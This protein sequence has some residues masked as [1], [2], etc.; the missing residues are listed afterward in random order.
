MKSS[1]LVNSLNAGEFSPFMGGRSDFAKYA[2][3]SK[4]LQNFI[5]LVQG[6][7]TRRGGTYHA[8]AKKT[9][10]SRG[11][12]VRFEFSAT[13][14]W[15][16]E[17]GD[18]Y[19]R[20][21][22]NHG[23]VVVSGVTAWS[24]VTAYV[25]GDLVVSG[26]INYYCIL[27]H[28]NQIPPN[29]TYWYALTG[30][31]YEI[32]SPYALADLTNA[33]GT[34]ALKF[35]Q[36]GDVIYIANQKRTYAPRKLTRYGSTNWQFSTYAPSTGPFLEQNITATTLYAS[37]NTGSVTLQ[38][39]A[40]IFA[41]S[42][43][44]RL[45]R[46]EVQDQD[47]APWETAKVYALNDLSRFDGK[48]YKVTDA[49][50]SGTSPPI[51]EH[52]KAYDGT[53]T[54][55]AVQWSYQESGYAI[56]RI[57]AFTDANTVTA[58]VIADEANG[59]NLV[60]AALVGAGT[61]SK[62]WSLGAWSATTEYPS[63][64]TFWRDRLCWAG[65]QRYWISVPNDFENM[66]GDFFNEVRADNAIWRQLQAE[67]VN[68]IVWLSGADELVIGTP[69]GEFVVTEITNSQ[70]LGPANIKHKR[71]S[72][73]RCR[74]VQPVSIGTKLVYA[75]RAGRKLLSFGYDFNTDKFRSQDLAVLADRMTRAGIVDMA[76]Q[77]EPFPVMWCVLSN[78]G[79]IGFTYD[80][81]NEV[82]GWHRHPLGGKEVVVESVEV[83]PAPNGLH[84]EVWLMV[85]RTINAATAR[86]I[87]YM[88]R[89]WEGVD[90]DGQGG[91]D[92]QDAFYVDAGLT[93]EGAPDTV[94][95]DDI[96]ITQ[97][98]PHATPI[99]SIGT[100][101]EHFLLV[102]QSIVVT[103]IVATGSYVLNG[104]LTVKTVIS[105]TRFTIQFAG[106]GA[107][108][109][110][111][112]SGGQFPSLAALA[113]TITG[114]DHLEGETV[115]ILTDGAVHPDRTVVSGDI[116]LTAPA[117]VAHIG[118]A[119]PARIVTSDLEAGGQAGTSMG[120]AA[121][122]YWAAVRFVDT[123]GGMI[124]RPAEDLSEPST[125]DEIEY[126][127]PDNAMDSPP[128]TLSGIVDVP[129]PGEWEREKSVEIL[130]YQPLP[131]TVANIMPRLH[132]NDD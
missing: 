55:A 32:P 126:R 74:A 123:L 65:A 25:I 4:L 60:P 130:Q 115:S 13:Q 77:A 109:G 56:F 81:N 93:Y 37:A 71:H 100:T 78:G 35:V 83:I 50:T 73:Y 36:S 63:T 24:G 68:D 128:P 3:S 124:G 98:F 7:V 105:P 14:A 46:L 6:P 96:T 2:Y 40:D 108:S 116:V 9:S 66:A 102:G 85:K 57:T 87:E 33:D 114:L 118:L 28:T 122:I 39:S 1:P 91:D 10:A 111:Y 88:K 23:Q 75:Q 64:V 47:V 110:S 26:G 97:T 61:P 94:F 30:A 89:P 11:W 117:R 103:G 29:A 70:P 45:V 90:N 31:I 82:T 8:A 132:V 16:L 79:L 20:F 5:A 53:P 125:L 107:V 58:T 12:L 76:F 48:T 38:S 104:T 22:T 84:D 99:V 131:M 112:V 54:T 49:G 27:G 69:G 21:F 18:L 80:E 101:A 127:V 120:K 15:I 95:I 42:D 41:A 52:G 106:K 17:F 43:V 51:H 119:C 113:T 92:P 34:C 129:F 67:D 59:L 44:G 86:H 72:K 121:R 19:L 62:R